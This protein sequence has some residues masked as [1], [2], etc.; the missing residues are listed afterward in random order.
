MKGETL[1]IFLDTPEL[2]EAQREALA[3]ELQAAVERHLPGRPVR[4][5]SGVDGQG[6]RWLRLVIEMEPGRSLEAPKEVRG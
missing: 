2:P 4:L 1:E 3:R 6:R 5:L